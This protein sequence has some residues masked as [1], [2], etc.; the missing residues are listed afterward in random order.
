MDLKS[1]DEGNKLFSI[2]EFLG[3]V[4]IQVGAVSVKVR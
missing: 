4:N 2:L 3:K 1:A